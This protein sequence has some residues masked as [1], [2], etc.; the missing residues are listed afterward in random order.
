MIGVGIDEHTFAAT[1]GASTVE[2]RVGEDEPT[3]TANGGVRVVVVPLGQWD[4]AG[5]GSVWKHS[6]YL[7]ISLQDNIVRYRNLERTHQARHYSLNFKLYIFSAN[8]P[9]CFPNRPL[10]L[11][12]LGNDTPLSA[13]ASLTGVLIDPEFAPF[14]K[15]CLFL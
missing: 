11:A 9:Y 4:E 12:L 8:P 10:F 13:I 14:F 5:N 7:A 3:E 15:N 6:L 1:Q 2:L